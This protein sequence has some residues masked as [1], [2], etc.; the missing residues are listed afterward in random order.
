VNRIQDFTSCLVHGILDTG[1]ISI[2][3]IK[4]KQTSK[5][6]Q[7]K[8]HQKNFWQQMFLLAHV[9]RLQSLFQGSQDKIFSQLL[10]SH[11]RSKPGRNGSINAYYLA[12]LRFSYTVQEPTLEMAAHFQDGSSQVN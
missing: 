12:N 9:S 8:M 2:A 3:L 6:K 10:T 11:P 5:S 4:N 1:F 7:T